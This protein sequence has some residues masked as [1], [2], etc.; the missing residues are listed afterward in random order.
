MKNQISVNGQ[1]TRQ[2]GQYNIDSSA[3]DGTE[4]KNNFWM[5][6]SLFLLLL[7][8]GGVGGFMFVLNNQKSTKETATTL[9]NTA[10]ITPEVTTT[11]DNGNTSASKET[12]TFGTSYGIFYPYSDGITINNSKPTIIGRVSQSS[13]SYLSTKFGI[14]K[15][16]V[17]QEDEYFLRF[18]PGK[19]INL[20]VKIDNSVIQDVYGIAQYPTVFCKGINLNPDGTSSYDPQAGNKFPPDDI[21]TSEIECFAQKNSDIPPLIFFTKPTSQ[22]SP[23]KH[24]LSISSQGKAIGS[25]SFNIDNNFKLPIQNVA[26]KTQSDY[27]SF[28]D[29]VDYC[30]EGYYYD[31]NFLKIPLPVHNNRNLFYG[32]SF[33]QTKEEYGSIKRRQVQIGFKGNRFTLFFPESIVFYDGKSFIYD[34]NINN[35]LVPEKALFLPKDHLFFTD[36]KRANPQQIS[37]DGG[38]NG[39][40]YFEIY[41]IDQGGYEYR[42]FSL[43]WQTSGSSGC[44]G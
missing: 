38:L 34:G 41:P 12:E 31:S 28:F 26:K 4:M 10:S 32:I 16:P 5:Y 22:L 42:D 3:R 33:P 7:L 39:G 40:E 35:T 30:A 23:G 18:I 6:A 21:F 25:M 15:S 20:E 17:S 11:I 37:V 13:H 43:P 24:T 27:F 14:E 9:T 36:G 44:D 29:I 19:T 2:I 8:A 1:N